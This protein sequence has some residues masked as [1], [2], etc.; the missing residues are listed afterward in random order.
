MAGWGTETSMDLNKIP[1]W[2][3]IL[4]SVLGIGAC[5]TLITTARADLDKFKTIAYQAKNVSDSNT[6][7]ITELKSSVGD[8]RTAQETFRREYREDRNRDAELLRQMEDRIVKA[9]KA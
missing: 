8:I 6:S 4:I 7:S 5:G 1:R 2:A 9:V 3:L